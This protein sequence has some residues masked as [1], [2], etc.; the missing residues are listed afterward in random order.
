MNLNNW[1]DV[2]SEPG[3]ERYFVEVP[4]GAAGAPGTVTRG[5]RVL[6]GTTPVVRNSAGNYD[7]FLVDGVVAIARVDPYIETTAGNAV[8]AGAATVVR[9]I[10]RTPNGANPKV[11]ILCTSALGTPVATDPANGDILLLE[12]TAINTN[13][14]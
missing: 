6:R 7:F 12:I 8:G 5:G 4:I 9:C 3:M 11:S 10:G 13:A 2:A 14:G 1:E